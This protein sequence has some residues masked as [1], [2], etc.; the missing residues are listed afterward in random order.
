MPVTKKKK[1]VASANASAKTPTPIVVDPPDFRY[2]EF[3]IHGTSP[4][5][6]QR[7][8][9][10]TGDKMRKAQEEGGQAKAK[11]TRDPK[12]FEQ[13]YQDAQYISEEG[14]NGINANSFRSAMI[15]AARFAGL[16]MV[17]MKGAIFVEADGKDKYDETD[18]IKII[19]K[20]HMHVGAVRN[21]SG[22]AD[23]R[24]RPMWKTWKCRLR[25]RYD[26]GQISAESVANLLY[27]AGQQIGIGEGRP[28]S[29]Q[30]NG[31]G[32][33]LFTTIIGKESKN[34]A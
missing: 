27:R 23:L 18:L 3:E 14:W 20:H 22:V 6:Q 17:K 11:K 26:A 32:W 8:S 9:Q 7:F 31:M 24:A 1:T 2:V 4:F 15:E 34:A 5:C 19:G 13:C 21:A 28:M 10:K 16:V 29:R 25:I 33:G 30:S 12:N